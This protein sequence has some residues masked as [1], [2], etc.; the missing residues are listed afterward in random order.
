MRALLGILLALIASTA[1]AADTVT[2]SNT[3]NSATAGVTPA[4][5]LAVAIIDASGNQAGIIGN[6]L[7]AQAAAYALTSTGFQQV[8]SF[9]TSTGFTPPAGSTVCFIQAEGNSVRFRTD[10]SAPTATIGQLLATGVLL[11]ETANLAGI[12]FI[13]TTGNATLD[14]DCYR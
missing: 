13:P 4:G 6:P 9:S 10:G 3:Q 5:G 14:V 7:V 8:A 12:K 1:F 11:Q 2:I